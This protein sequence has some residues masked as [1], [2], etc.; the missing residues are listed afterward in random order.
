MHESFIFKRGDHRQHWFDADDWKWKRKYGEE[1]VKKDE[2]KVRKE[3]RVEKEEVVKADGKQ[4]QN[5][6]I[7]KWCKGEWRIKE[8]KKNKRMIKNKDKKKERRKGESEKEDDI[9][10]DREGEEGKEE[11]DEVWGSFPFF[12]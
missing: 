8:K 10:K 5:R 11:D 4:E 12:T 2:N 6:E 9:R 7:E 1:V 3:R